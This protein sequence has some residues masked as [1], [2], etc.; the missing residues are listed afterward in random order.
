M[1]IPCVKF[2]CGLFE[3]NKIK[4]GWESY[5]RGRFLKMNV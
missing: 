1:D 2:L 4:I 3:T 5:V